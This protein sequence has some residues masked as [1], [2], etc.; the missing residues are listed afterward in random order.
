MPLSPKMLGLAGEYIALLYLL[1]K[2]YS[3]LYHRYQCKAGEID[4]IAQKRQLLIFVEVKTRRNLKHI[5]LH[6][7]ISTQQQKRIQN[8]AHY[9]RTKQQRFRQF[10]TRCD[11]IYI[12]PWR[13][14]KH[15]KNI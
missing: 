10:S 14:P 6:D 13:W 9:F 12:Q 15:I 2:G 3:I 11:G 7:I 8:T 4:I 5:P 1:C